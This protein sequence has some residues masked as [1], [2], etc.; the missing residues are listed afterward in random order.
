MAPQRGRVGG[1]Q[2]WLRKPALDSSCLRSHPPEENFVPTIWRAPSCL[3]MPSSW[4]VRAKPGIY[5]D[6]MQDFWRFLS[7]GPALVVDLESYWQQAFSKCS[8]DNCFP[9]WRSLGNMTNHQ[10]RGTSRSGNRSERWRKGLRRATQ[11]TR[12]KVGG[13]LSPDRAL[14]FPPR[15]SSEGQRGGRSPFTTPSRTDFKTKLNPLAASKE[16]PSLLSKPQK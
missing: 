12:R 16:L 4:A 6:K 11:P 3:T 13:A 5:Q 7:S 9:S 2:G 1:T 8:R 10:N 15:I 14:C